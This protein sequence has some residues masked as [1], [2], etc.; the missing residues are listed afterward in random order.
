MIQKPYPNDKVTSIQALLF[1]IFGLILQNKDGAQFEFSADP[2]LI[3]EVFY[4][5]RDIIDEFMDFRTTG[6]YP[7]SDDL[8]LALQDMLTLGRWIRFKA[9]YLNIYVLQASAKICNE[10]GLNMFEDYD[11]QLIKKIAIDFVCNLEVT[12]N[13]ITLGIHF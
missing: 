8:E 2:E 6:V 5:H 7:Y 13:K 9:N 4:K 10:F 3:N 11:I 12:K 1:A